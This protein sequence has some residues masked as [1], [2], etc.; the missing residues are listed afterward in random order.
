MR[1][2]FEQ[3]AD[4]GNNILSGSTGLLYL[5]RRFPLDFLGTPLGFLRDELRDRIYFVAPPPR[6][7][8]YKARSGLLPDTLATSHSR[9]RCITIHSR[10]APQND[11]A[12]FSGRKKFFLGSG[13]ENALRPSEAVW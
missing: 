12:G 1:G 11:S 7:T 9:I 5:F 13:P 3:S 8:Y 2:S 6:W 10:K 4:I